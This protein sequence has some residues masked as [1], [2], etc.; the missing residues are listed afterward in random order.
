[1]L[2][3]SIDVMVTPSGS[4][5]AG[6]ILAASRKQKAVL[7]VGVC[8]RMSYWGDD[9]RRLGFTYEWSHGHAPADEEPAKIFNTPGKCNYE[10]H[11]NGPKIMECWRGWSVSNS[12]FTVNV[13]KL[14]ADLRWT[15]DELCRDVGGYGG[16]ATV[17]V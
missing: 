9:A 6:L 3:N 8:L 1:M 7:E 11:G 14:E 13:T 2:F 5:L 4:Q 10:A 16:E 17:S 15:L 12:A